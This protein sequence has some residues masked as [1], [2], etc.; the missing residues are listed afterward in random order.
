M[1]I[2]THYRHR[3]QSLRRQVGAA[4]TETLVTL[5]ILLLLGLG[6]V[7]GALMVNAKNIVTYATFEAARKGAVNHAQVDPIQE[8]LGLRI[9]PLMGG[10]GTPDLAAAAIAQGLLETKNPLFTKVEQLNPTKEAFDDFGVVNDDGITEIPNTFLSI[11]DR[12][13]GAT[14]KVTIQDAN[15]LKI[16]VTYAYKLT[17][18]LMDRVIP[19]VLT[20]VDPDNA[21]TYALRRIPVSAVATVRM[22]SEAFDGDHVAK[23]DGSGGGVVPSEPPEEEDSETPPPEDEEPVE[24]DKEEDSEDTDEG[25]EPTDPEGGSDEEAP[26]EEEDIPEDEEETPEEEEEIV[27][28]TSWEDERYEIPHRWWSPFNWSDT[29]TAVKNILIDLLSGVFDGLKSQLNDLIELITNPSVLLDV[30]RAMVDDFDEFA[31][32]M[33]EALVTDAK[34]VLE[35]G[36]KDIGRI[37]G[38]NANPVQVVRVLGRLTKSDVLSRHADDLDARITKCASFPAGTPIW[39][40]SGPVAIETL[41]VGD[42]VLSRDDQTLTNNQQKITKT[43]S[44]QAKGYQRIRTEFGVINATPEHPFWVQG[45]GWVKAKDLKWEDPI[46]TLEGDVVI[47]END[48]IPGPVQVY[49]FAVDNTHNYFAGDDKLWVHNADDIVCELP[50]TRR[51]IGDYAKLD[52]LKDLPLEVLKRLDELD[53]DEKALKRL[54]EDF[55]SGGLKDAVKANDKLLDSWKL[56]DDT[57]I[58]EGLR[59]NPD[60]LNNMDEAVEAGLDSLDAIEDAIQTVAKPKPSWAEIRAL[61]KRGNDFNKKAVRDE[62]YP[63]HEVHLSNGKRLDS[64]D[65]AK[66]EIISRKATDLDG[67]KRSTFEGYLKELKTKYSEGMTIR[68]NKYGEIDGTKLTGKQILEIPESNKTASKLKEYTDLA[69]EYGV[70]IRF[71]PE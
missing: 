71:R 41:S 43:F 55:A 7:Q 21:A 16:K 56:L 31:K 50:D 11:R 36:P 28:E 20:K 8:E 26:T 52:N 10:D 40:T 60:V 15:L 2:L 45:K 39:K 61:F 38:E 22:Q 12:E 18:P 19:A 14:S 57:G 5:P 48:Y 70:E 69:A 67:I 9:A 25:S 59:R 42:T 64:Y 63:Y 53:L 58:H 54:D 44:R 62:W 66:G 51:S 24:P 68:S 1:T 65:P 32:D 37:I 49:N 3:F 33:L 46:A 23:A 29:Y 34:T 4:M 47:Y 13:V 17:V 30:A 27:C 6:S 35:C